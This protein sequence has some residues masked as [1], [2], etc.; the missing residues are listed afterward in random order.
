ME[1][2]LKNTQY[3]QPQSKKRGWLIFGVGVFLILLIIGFFLF[4]SPQINLSEDSTQGL[5][6]EGGLVQKG[7]DPIK[8]EVDLRDGITNDS[9]LKVKLDTPQIYRVGLGYQKVAQF[10]INP[11]QDY[12]NLLG[13]FEFIDLKTGK[14]IDRQMDIKYLS[15]ENYDVND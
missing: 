9:I 1:N 8:N 10:T 5:H 12:E 14:E 6:T 4:K 3:E 11:E 13:D 7:F 2:Y 15:L